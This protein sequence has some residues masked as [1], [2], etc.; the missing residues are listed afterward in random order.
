MHLVHT[1]AF[2]Q[3]AQKLMPPFAESPQATQLGAVEPALNLIKNPVAQVTHLVP[4]VHYSQPEGQLTHT[5]F[6]TSKNYP[7]GQM[8]YTCK[9]LKVFLNP[10]LVEAK[11]RS[12]ISFL[13]GISSATTVL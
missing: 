13:R 11:L 12:S 3:V 9:S 5:E 2:A 4:L 6:A 1:F 10:V 8:G 7:S